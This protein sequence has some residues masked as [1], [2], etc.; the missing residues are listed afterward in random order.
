M[1]QVWLQAWA[2]MPE[3]PSLLCKCR[4]SDAVHCRLVRVIV[5]QIM[6]N[7]LEQRDYMDLVRRTTSL[8][9]LQ[10]Q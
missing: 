1:A 9:V 3:N 10:G 8:A 6:E 2:H 4:N 5:D 7:V